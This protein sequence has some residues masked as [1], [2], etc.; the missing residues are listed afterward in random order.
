MPSLEPDHPSPSAP[1]AAAH[2]AARR[3]RFRPHERVRDPRDFRRAFALRRPVSDAV[4]VV[5]AVPNG[6][7][8]SRLGISVPRKLTRKAVVRNRLK[9]CIREAFRISKS[10]LPA[11]LDLIVVPRAADLSVHQAS[12]SLPVLVRDAARRL[13]LGLPAAQLPPS[14]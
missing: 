8:H 9:R 1:A 2:E 11:G 4:I 6:L 12:A 13:G 3:C 7:P 10:A 5:H 14:P